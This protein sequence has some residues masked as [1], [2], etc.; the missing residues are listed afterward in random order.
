MATGFW[1]GFGQGWQAE[2]D[3]I[4]RR[5]LFMDEQKERR[6]EMILDLA[7]RTGGA[8]L[9]GRASGT[10][11]ED[12]TPNPNAVMESL[13]NLG[14][15]ESA[16]A[17]VMSED[18][19]GQAG[20]ALI[21]ELEKRAD[22]NIPFT[23][24]FATSI[25]ENYVID[26][27]QGQATDWDSVFATY[28]IDDPEMAA[29]LGNIP[30]KNVVTTYPG[31]IPNKPL[32]QSEI[33]QGIQNLNDT[34]LTKLYEGKAYWDQ[35]ID[36]NPEAADKAS[37][38]QLAIDSIEKNKNPAPGRA[39]VG[40]EMM[41]ALVEN[42]HRFAEVNLGPWGNISQYQ[43]QAPT[44]TQPAA[45]VAPTKAAPIRQFATEGEVRAAYEAGQL[46]VGDV[47]M[48]NGEQVVIQ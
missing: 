17:R 4:E 14:V 6:K 47:V 36:S 9:G 1:A 46:K 48:I 18:P 44:E 27:Q 26:V 5:K 21:K 31:K 30:P 25:A 32:T 42:D 41:Q 16:V 2:S 28:G 40:G 39:L 8:G 19:T 7:I 23:P 22:P 12:T 13:V 15:A 10:D 37:E 43:E 24:E 45:E 29:A 20:A 11:A 3:R 38:F 35:Y 34:L 33:N